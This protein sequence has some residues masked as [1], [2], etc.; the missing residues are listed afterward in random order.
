[1]L[2]V[3]FQVCKII[4]IILINILQTKEIKFFENIERFNDLLWVIIS[5]IKKCQT[6]SIST[7]NPKKVY[8]IF[9]DP[10]SNTLFPKML[11]LMDEMV[12]FISLDQRR[13]LI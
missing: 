2:F 7:M 13:I 11:C 8:S 5:Q 1:M 4:T 12:V 3:S 9:D 6:D 10:H